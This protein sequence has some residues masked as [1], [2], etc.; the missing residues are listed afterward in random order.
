MKALLVL[1]VVASIFQAAQTRAQDKSVRLLLVPVET[2]IKSRSVVSFDVYLYNPTNHAKK[3]ASLNRIS[4]FYR[5][6]DITGA[7]QARDEAWSQ[8]VADPPPDHMLQPN[9][10]EHTRISINIPSEPGDLVEIHLEVDRKSLVR[11]NSVLLF[12]PTGKMATR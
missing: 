5:L 12:C 3:I 1:A 2:T 7:R 11:S 9:S 4:G 6:Q 10:T 8:I